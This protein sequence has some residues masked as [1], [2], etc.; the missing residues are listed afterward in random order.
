[1]VENKSINKFNGISKTSKKKPKIDKVLAID[2][3]KIKHMQISVDLMRYRWSCEYGLAEVLVYGMLTTWCNSGIKTNSIPRLY[4]FPSH[5]T[6]AETTGYSRQYISKTI[7]NLAKNGIIRILM[8]MRP[9]GRVARNYYFLMPKIREDMELI[10]N[11][12]SRIK[13]PEEYIDMEIAVSKTNYPNH[14]MV[15]IYE[16][17]IKEV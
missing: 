10:T 16:N 8:V 17:I 6:L 11:A 7:E 9:N 13:T 4:A 5:T 15:L 12:T 3:D 1:M 14:K 2:Y